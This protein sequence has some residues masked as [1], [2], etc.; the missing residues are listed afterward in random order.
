MRH[1]V[2]PIILSFI[3]ISTAFA[4]PTVSC[5]CFQDRQYVPQK[6]GAADPY[7][8]ATTQNSLM[9]ALFGIDKKSLVR[10]KM[11]GNDGDSLW[12]TYYL[13]QQTVKTTAEISRARSNAA[14]WSDAV[15]HLKIDAGQLDSRFVGLLD[16]PEALAAFIV[17]ESLAKKLKVER[18]L[19]VSLRKDGAA[20]NELIL[21]VFLGL[22]SGTDPQFNYNR[23]KE[24]E[25]WGKLLH[26]LGVFDG[27]AIE[28]KWASLLTE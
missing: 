10:A 3:F 21:A 26:G 1:I 17:D 7:F 22:I 18:A 27:A 4:A 20:N 8:L 25:S 15:S 14:S 12:I 23:F 13:A 6:A 16:K 28:H 5:H 24:G 2:L 19:L 9:A 11:S